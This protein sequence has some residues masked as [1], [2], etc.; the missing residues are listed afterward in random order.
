MK[1]EISEYGAFV[2]K[3]VFNGIMLDTK[4]GNQ[5]G[6][7]MRDDTLE[8]NVLPK[9]YIEDYSDSNWYRVNMQEGTIDLMG[10]ASILLYDDPAKM[11]PT[12]PQ[13][14]DGESPPLII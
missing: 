12:T 4:E 11:S 7:C 1:I 6:I 3:E 8:I 9:G 14:G 5:I 13:S 2:L 10:K